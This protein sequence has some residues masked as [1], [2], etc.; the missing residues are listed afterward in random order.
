MSSCLE[1][2]DPDPELTNPSYVK[3]YKP[4]RIIIRT[5]T[6]IIIPL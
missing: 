4:P 5:A 6:R 1:R 2:P 3:K